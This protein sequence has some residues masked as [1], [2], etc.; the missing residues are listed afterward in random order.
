MT[1]YQADEVLGKVREAESLLSTLA[2]GAQEPSNSDLHDAKIHLWKAMDA[3]EKAQM[4]SYYNGSQE[5]EWPGSEPDP[6][7][8]SF[9]DRP[10]NDCACP[11]AE[12][13]ERAEKQIEHQ[14]NR[15]HEKH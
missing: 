11:E 2:V 14:E 15:G 5:R 12:R 1:R 13:L 9:C 3:I 10:K 8:C 4:S 7:W 6:E